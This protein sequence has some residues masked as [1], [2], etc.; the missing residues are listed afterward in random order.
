LLFHNNGDGTF[1]EAAAQ[2]G[3]ALMMTRVSRGA[4]FGD[5]FN[6]GH[7][8]VVVNNLDGKPTILRNMGANP[9][10]NWITFKLVGIGKNPDAIGARAK[11]VSGEIVQWDEVRAGGSYIS[12][13]DMR[14]HF[15]LGQHSQV[16]F[17][18]VH[19][20]DGKV[21]TVKNPPLNN[22]VTIQYGKGS[23]KVMLPKATTN[24]SKKNKF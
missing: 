4:A 23:V 21:E 2:N 3:E 17:V 13:N 15:G 14:L 7:I 20:P 11:V 10:N 24:T 22:F 9:E 5:L 8:D 19:W 12:S 6:D 18:E 16:D 1:T